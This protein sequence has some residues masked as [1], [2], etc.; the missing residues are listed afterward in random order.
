VPVIGFVGRLQFDRGLDA[1]V[2]LIG[3]L[4]KEHKEFEVQVIGSG[5][6]QAWLQ[7]QFDDNFPDIK[8]EFVGEVTQNEMQA[9]WERLDLSISCAPTESYGRAVRESIFAGVPVLATASS[10]VQSM[11]EA[12]Q[13]G[14]IRLFD[15]KSQSLELAGA[16]DQLLTTK[17][18]IEFRTNLA[19]EDQANLGKIIEQWISLSA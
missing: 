11:N 18:P 3:K 16:F 9:Y 15:R 19:R 12:I 8:V 6:E 4:Q 13:N 10:G 1:F 5:P 14:Y 17:L 2:D 7:R